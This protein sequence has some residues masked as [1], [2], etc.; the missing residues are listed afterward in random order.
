MMDGIPMDPELIEE[1]LR[2]LRA[3]EQGGVDPHIGMSEGTSD[4]TARLAAA[5]SALRR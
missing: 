4:E 1:A 5:L 3:K 2:Q